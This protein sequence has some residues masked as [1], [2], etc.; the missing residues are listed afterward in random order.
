MLWNYALPSVCGK[1]C[2]EEWQKHSEAILKKASKHGF[3]SL[4]AEAEEWYSNS[5]ELTVENVI[6]KF[7]EADGNDFAIER[8]APKKFMIDHAEEILETEAFERL[9]ESLPLLKEVF[10]AAIQ[11]SKKRKRH[12]E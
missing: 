6:D 2:P 12:V 3:T 9:H 5:L 8:H 10:A 7:L 11:N 4:K 1:V